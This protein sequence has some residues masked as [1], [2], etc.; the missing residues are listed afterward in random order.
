MQT[1]QANEQGDLRPARFRPALALAIPVLAA[2]TAMLVCGPQDLNAQTVKSGFIINETW[3]EAGSP[4]VIAGDIL[5]LGL[6]IESNVTV[7]FAGDYAFEV[8]GKLEVKGAAGAEVLFTPQYPT[9]SWQGIVFKD[10]VPGSYFN[11]A[12][13]EGSHN[14][15]V[16][17]TNTPPAFTNCVVRNNTS[18]THGG[19]L[20]AVVSG[21]PLIL[22]NCLVTSNTAGLHSGDRYG[23]GIMVE[24]DCLVTGCEIVWN[25]TDGSRYGY[26]G[27]IFARNGDCAIL[28]SVIAYNHSYASSG[29][30]GDGIYLGTGNHLI[31][32]SSILTNGVPFGNGDSAQGG[33][34]RY[35]DSG[36]ARMQ[37]CIVA[38]NAH[39]GITVHAGTFSAVN[40]TI[41]ANQWHGVDRRS[42]SVALTNSII[43]YNYEPPYQITGSATIAYCDV[44]GGVLPGPGN[45]SFAPALCPDNFSLIPGSPCID[46]GN[47]DSVFNDSCIDD[48]VCA[49]YSR[50]TARNDMGAYGGRGACCNLAPCDV[51]VIA[52]QPRDASSCLG[53]SAVFT[54]GATGAEPLLYQWFLNGE[55][56]AGQTNAQLSLSSLTRD[57]AGAYTVSIQNQFGQATSL[58]AQLIVYDACIDLRMYAGLT[59]TGQE[60]GN[61]VLS[62]TTD[63]GNPTSWTPLA[64]NMMSQSGWFYLDLES[65]FSP[66]RFYRADL[67]P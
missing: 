33:G 44:Q 38:G 47:P 52:A 28:N 9:N 14:S 35:S 37:N 21:Y 60:G 29:Q 27:G 13:I 40:S 2:A 18:P 16:R 48:T 8:A 26:G 65:P 50:G 55:T 4:Y 6:T 34:L 12:I 51:P 5:V 39:H 62:Y 58:P 19:G 1:E 57:D 41:A 7:Q 17:I 66:Q 46:A 54:I 20:M 63:L 64:T 22:Q 53:G 43:Y 56:L 11:H 32:N 36:T 10:A 59:I 3:P 31:A 30:Y 49:P 24:G 45:I 67:S 42:G 25:K 15:G 61:Y 23:G